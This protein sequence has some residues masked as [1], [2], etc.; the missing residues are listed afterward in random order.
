MATGDD[1]AQARFVPAARIRLP[2][3]R[4]HRRH[5]LDE[6]LA[7][8]WDRRLGLI[9]APA[10]SGKTTLLVQFAERAGV[11]VA[12]YRA[13]PGD[14]DAGGFLAA[15]ERACRAGFEPLHRG[16]RSAADAAEAL[17]AWPGGRALVIVDDLH[18]LYRTE[19]E[20]ALGQ[21]VDY[22]PP[23]IFLLAGSRRVPG[24][25]LSRLRLAGGLLELGPDDLRFRSWEVESLFRDFYG[26][27]LPPEDLAE[28]ARRTGG[29]SAGLQ[30][31]HLASQ[32]KPTGERRRLVAELGP[33]WRLVR[34]YLTR[35]VLDELP[36][37]LRR[38]LVETSV[39]GRLT[40]PLCDE[41]LGRPGSAVILEELERRQ[42]FTTAVDDATWRYHEVLRSHL[43]VVLV[44]EEGE[45]SVRRRYARAAALLEA[46]GASADAVR[47]YCRAEDWDAAVRLLG[48][49]GEQLVGEGADWAALP[50][51]LADN[52][53]WL[54]LA[55]ARR[56]L[57]SGHPDDALSAYQAAEAAFGT[58]G[59][60]AVCRRERLAVTEWLR[61]GTT[62]GT[63][64]WVTL[65]RAATR[66]NPVDV[67]EAAS[68]LPGAA[69]CLAQGVAALLAGRLR[70]GR[71]LLLE[72]AERPDASPLLATA[73]KVA[74]LAGGWYLG[75][76]PEGLPDLADEAE[77]L[78][79]PW[80]VRLTRALVVTMPG[81]ATS[82]ETARLAAR[83]R[84]EGD[85]WGAAIMTFALGAQALVTGKPAAALLAAAI[86]NFRELDAGVLEAWAQSSLALAQAQTGQPEAA[87]MARA[88]EALARNLGVPGAQALA[89]TA[90]AA[91]EPERAPE[92]LTTAA[93]VDPEGDVLPLSQGGSRAPSGEPRPAGFV[94]R[95]DE[96]V[97]LLVHLDGAQAGSG[98]VVAVIGEAGVGKTRLV[99]Q[100]VDLARAR[101]VREVAV[102][103]TDDVARLAEVLGEAA[104][105]APQLAVIDDVHRGNPKVSSALPQ[106]DDELGK[107]PVLVVVVGR[108]PA[109]DSPLAPALARLDPR[110]LLRL[111]GFP[112]SDLET[113]VGQSLPGPVPAGLTDVLH[114]RTGGN[115]L[116]T[117]EIL[118][119]L[120]RQGRFEPEQAAVVPVP[121][122]VRHAVVE[123]LAHLPAATVELLQVGSVVGPAFDLAL[124]RATLD[125]GETEILERLGPAV[126]IGVV[127]ELGSRRFGFTN[128]LSREVVYERMEPVERAAW[129]ERVGGALEQRHT[130]RS[131]ASLAELTHH[132]SRAAG[133]G[134]AG[135]AVGYALRA[136]DQALGA[137]AIGEAAELYRTALN[138]AEAGSTG[139]EATGRALIGIGRA[140]TLAGRRREGRRFLL[141]AV[142][143]ARSTGNRAL[144]ARAALEIDGVA[145]D[146][147]P[148]DAAAQAL[149]REAR[150]A[151]GADEEPMAALL[152]A[153]L[154]AIAYRAG[155]AA[156]FTALAGQARALAARTGD[157]GAQARALEVW[158]WATSGPD[159]LAARTAVADEMLAAASAAGDT[160]LLLQAR[161]Y[162]LR[163]ALEAGDQSSA[164]RQLNAL[165]PFLDEPAG[166]ASSELA[167]LR[168]MRALLEGRFAAVE[169]LCRDALARAPAG[170]LRSTEIYL[171]Q[172]LVLRREQG[173]AGELEPHIRSVV[174]QP[175]S[176]G[177]RPVLAWLA[178]ETGR[179]AEAAARLERFVSDTG[180]EV[181]EQGWLTSAFF[182][183]ETGVR[184]G[185]RERGDVLYRALRPW[186]GRVVVIGLGV[187]CL[188]TVDDVLG[189]LAAAAGRRRLAQRHFEA[190][191]TLS[192]RLGARPLVARTA[193]EYAAVLRQRGAT[194][195]AGTLLDEARRTAEELGM[196][197]VLARV[198][199]VSGATAL[200][201]VEP[202]L[203]AASSSPAPSSAA[204]SEATSVEAPRAV[205][206]CLGRFRL[207]LDGR[208]ID[209]TPAKPRVRQA[210][211]LLAA[212]AGDPVHRESIVEALWPDAELKAGMHNLQVTISSLRRLLEPEASRGESSLIVRQGDAYR[213]ALPEP[214]DIDLVAFEGALAESRAALKS[215]ATEAAAA[216]LD[217]ARAAYGGDLL[218]EDG[219]AE[220]VVGRREELRTEAAEAAL[221]RAR[222]A[223][224]DGNFAAA[225]ATCEWGLRIDRY[226][227]TLWRLL[228]RARQQ[229]GDRAAAERAQRSYEEALAELG[230]PADRRG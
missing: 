226:H 33:R 60:A 225:A 28:L 142:D 74:A 162:R 61:P 104:S 197:A 15:L 154:A 6:R 207:E 151:Y 127:E 177:W 12:F 164:D 216:A 193:C 186:Q 160:E 140:E 229:A 187:A 118:A 174:E 171:A 89:L 133:P 202:A 196:A 230:L 147:Q 32:G 64:D 185:D 55:G 184:V 139:D 129:H 221:A 101:G 134:T 138:L 159:E 3:I 66:R 223:L 30:L 80:L 39:L 130:D 35:N 112:P 144:L 85:R 214:A 200:P 50:A 220:W 2:R 10:G 45:E 20:E 137:G 24:I 77:R 170:R 205:L 51:R 182:L 44:E 102:P 92:H 97:E 218:P 9:V 217:R 27:P 31:F 43:E 26:E 131:S 175:S 68:R 183:A 179:V 11:P 86:A 36:D 194:A 168:A 56:H 79:V 110:R 199:A 5:R 107:E 87:E 29:W 23:S 70:F 46:A 78:S 145:A 149:L 228:V 222:L 13:E 98:G 119:V 178:A 143:L 96:L 208:V 8:L 88:A 123:D 136:A 150:E 91:A 54:L 198:E 128:E 59:P 155:D 210:L 122:V 41:F 180:L 71:E 206:R 114:R 47:A 93:A 167:G 17:E 109:P 99:E 166:L 163:D 16:W 95:G 69:A 18:T 81:Q 121:A 115:P 209:L 176:P 1:A 125:V 108:P 94:G 212:R 52:D 14:A 4:S 37:E 7:P 227:D 100:L 165:A 116:Y 156:R 84:A 152:E 117:L 201:A 148:R 188:G 62:G 67:M 120:G 21:L 146:N 215:G 63:A 153:R 172:M 126:R 124:L 111:R 181:P 48:R 75:P 40:G 83:A 72:A 38:F 34:E 90:R 58:A 57:A 49:V 169:E 73:A 213:L 190:A 158:H 173:R 25:D 219:P 211:R 82:D 19:A 76:S 132:F 203:A 192:R 103:V 65:I 191:L 224:D 53:P 105:T 135:R 113:F 204:P 157:P 161:R 42:I 106:L 195:R 22:L 141:Q 189:R